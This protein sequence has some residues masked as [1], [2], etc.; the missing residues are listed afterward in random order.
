M[1]DTYINP[2]ITIEQFSKF[3][4]NAV[5]RMKKSKLNS[6][7]F[8][9]GGGHYNVP[10]KYYLG[11][12]NTVHLRGFNVYPIKKYGATVGILFLKKPC[13]KFNQLISWLN[14]YTSN[15]YG[16][17]DVDFKDIETTLYVARVCGKRGK[18]SKEDERGKEYLCHDENWCE[19]VKKILQKTRNTG[20]RIEVLRETVEDFENMEDS[21]RN[22]TELYGSVI[23]NLH[24]KIVTPGGKVKFNSTIY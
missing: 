20:D 9:A 1:V 21:I 2:V 3:F 17:K 11:L 16:Y 6:M 14:K 24:F 7:E 19:R 12:L 15:Q 18:W 10:E 5:K 22:E 13:A 23:H 8:I 4:N